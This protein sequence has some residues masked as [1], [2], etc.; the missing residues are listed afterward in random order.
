MLKNDEFQLSNVVWMNPVFCCV[1]NKVGLAP[2]S[3][4]V[5]FDWVTSC[6]YNIVKLREFDNV[7][8]VVVGEKGLRF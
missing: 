7:G 6:P 5:S 1:T 8:I 3:S 2:T 4:A